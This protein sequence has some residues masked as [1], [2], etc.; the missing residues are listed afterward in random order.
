MFIP[1]KR[2]QNHSG[3]VTFQYFDL[4][5]DLSLALSGF[6]NLIGLLKILL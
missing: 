2:D 6:R 3:A 4:S 5:F 1:D